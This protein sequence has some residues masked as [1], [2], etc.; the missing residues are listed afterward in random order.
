MRYASGDGQIGVDPDIMLV[1]PM[2]GPGGVRASR[3]RS[4]QVR[5]RGH[6]YIDVTVARGGSIQTLDATARKLNY[7]L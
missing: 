6:V 4:D 3:Y 7:K 1:V 5:P 2:T